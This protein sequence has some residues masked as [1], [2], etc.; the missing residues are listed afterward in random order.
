MKVVQ[1]HEEVEVL[2]A[3]DVRIDI[4]KSMKIPKSLKIGGHII[5]IEQKPLVEIDSECN[6]GWAIWEL[7]KIIIA[8]DIPETRQMEVLIHEV[9]HFVNIYL[10]EESVTYLAS[11][12][13][14]IWYDNKVNI[15][16]L[17]CQKLPKFQRSK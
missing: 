16:P 1:I 8:S 9:I 11:I 12:L 4:K 17:L 2:I 10:D 3:K 6:G 7:N 15:L 14:Q 13:F 5:T